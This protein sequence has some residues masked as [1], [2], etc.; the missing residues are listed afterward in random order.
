MLVQVERDY[1]L[2]EPDQD[3]PYMDSP[4]RLQLRLRAAELITKAMG[5]SNA[6]ER[7]RL[8]A[9]AHALIAKADEKAQWNGDLR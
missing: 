4:A 6:A 1:A 3:E 9:E 2:D 7:E 8:L 5:S